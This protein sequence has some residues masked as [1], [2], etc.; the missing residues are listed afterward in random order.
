[1]L[2][3]EVGPLIAKS[4]PVPVRVTAC[5]DGEALSVRVTVA[6]PNDPVAVGVNVTLRTQV[7]PPGTIVPLVQVVPVAMAK[8]DA[9]VPE[10]VGTKANDNGAPPVFVMV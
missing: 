7:L 1:M 6:G 4:I 2:T 3:G 8:L 10:S 5:V 9:L